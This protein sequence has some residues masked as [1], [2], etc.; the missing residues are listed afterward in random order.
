MAT[1]LI[2]LVLSTKKKEVNYPFPDGN[3]EFSV[4]SGTENHIQIFNSQISKQHFAI[5]TNWE[6][7]LFIYDLD[8]E[9]GTYVGDKR[10][11]KGE[12]LQLKSRE[13]IHLGKNG[14]SL[15]IG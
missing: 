7:F 15:Q 11:E 4:G 8:S 13:I 5:R 2:D 3:N 14:Y 9:Y 10:L 1:K 6:D 12:L